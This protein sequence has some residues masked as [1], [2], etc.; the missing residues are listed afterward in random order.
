M[1]IFGSVLQIT[2]SLFDYFISLDKMPFV[3]FFF[4]LLF[5]SGVIMSLVALVPLCSATVVGQRSVSICG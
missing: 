2:T 1:V 4:L 3:D 5:Q